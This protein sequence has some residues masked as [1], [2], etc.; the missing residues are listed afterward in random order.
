M[1]MIKI[2][3]TKHKHPKTIIEFKYTKET[4]EAI[5]YV[6]GFY[7]LADGRRKPVTK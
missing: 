7:T 5:S 6:D 3:N 2:R 1:S 4:I